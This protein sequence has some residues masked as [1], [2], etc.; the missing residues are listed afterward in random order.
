MTVRQ[1]A[2]G[3]WMSATGERYIGTQRIIAKARR[4]WEGLPLRSLGKYS[5]GVALLLVFV[6][7]TSALPVSAI[8]RVGGQLWTYDASML[9]A[10]LNATG[11]VTYTLSG[12][13]SVVA[14]GASYDA[15]IFTISGHLSANSTF[16]G[17]PYSVSTVLGGTQSESRGGVSTIREDSLQLTDM[18]IGSTPEQLLARVRTET[19]TT[20]SP[21]YLSKFNPDSTSPGDTWIENLTLNTITIVNGT[22]TQN[23]S[24]FV[25]YNV[26]VA[27]PLEDVTVGAGV[28]KALKI[29]VTDRSGARDVY[30]WSSKVQNFVVVKRYDWSSSEPRA[31]LSL[32]EFDSS[33]GNGTII[34]VI[35]GAVVVAVAVLI[36]AAIIHSKRPKQAAPPLQPQ[37]GAQRPGQ[38]RL[39][40]SPGVKAPD[41][42]EKDPKH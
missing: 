24:S 3:R 38:R 34:P 7:T 35:V 33:G 9:V 18:S 22:E 25:T 37:A 8:D 12:Q 13:D 21:P 16:F 27:S 15:D 5:P 39:R 32:K 42:I 19:S 31:L 41:L 36:L 26:V 14:N 28:F 20:Y 23:V 30:W 11:T 4:S 29:T 6:F 2:Q 1:K 10:G 40:P 17:V